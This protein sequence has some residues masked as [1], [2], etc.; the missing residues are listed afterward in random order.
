MLSKEA[1]ENA[2]QSRARY[3]AA[4]MK[5]VGTKMKKEKAEAF[6]KYAEKFGLRPGTLVGVLADIALSGLIDP[7]IEPHRRGNTRY[8]VNEAGEKVETSRFA[9]NGRVHTVVFHSNGSRTIT[10]C[11]AASGGARHTDVIEIPAPA[12]KKGKKS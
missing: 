1:E 8:S 7:L 2:R 5:M 6:E 11:Y 9:E 4:N 12:V 3:D 10:D